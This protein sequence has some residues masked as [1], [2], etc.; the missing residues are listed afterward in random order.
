MFK[1]I[2]HEKTN[3]ANKLIILRYIYYMC[4]FFLKI[5]NIPNKKSKFYNFTAAKN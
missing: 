3:K 5:I 2:Y 1:Y 4:F